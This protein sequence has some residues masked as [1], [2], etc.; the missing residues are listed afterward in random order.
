MRDQSPV[1]RHRGFTL[2]ELLVVIAI[3]A[4]LIAL[5]LPAVQQA[6]EAARRSQCKNN[7]KQLGLA[8]HNYH[9]T[10]QCF[11]YSSTGPQSLGNAAV[12]TQHT[13]N[14]L[15]L[16]YMEQA[17]LYNQIN[18]SADNC[19]AANLAVLNNRILTFQICPSNPFGSGRTACDGTVFSA[20]LCG[21]WSTG[22][23]CY[24]P[25]VGPAITNLWGTT[26]AEDCR[27]LGSPAYCATV[28]STFMATTSAQTPG[29]FNFC[30]VVISRIRDI[31]DGSSNT[32]LLCERKGELNQYMGLFTPGHQGVLTGMKINS[33]LI[34]ATSS[35]QYLV[36][37]GASSHH[38]GGAHFLLGDG[39]VRFISNNVDFVTYNYLGAKADGNVV[40]D[41]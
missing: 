35:T 13:W 12:G 21:N 24:A 23:M 28:G 34:N 20:Y 39:S 29:I 16:P 40:G 3:I 7:V 14:E 41:F 33:S 11:P 37:S 27:L 31:T 1:R 38:V 30:G 9:D 22:L 4:V 32:L 10:M 5:L 18:F 17:P 26:A 25:N 6:R 15:I 2:I 19:S 36:N 8:L